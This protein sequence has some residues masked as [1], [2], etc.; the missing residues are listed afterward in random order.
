M[1]TKKAQKA[2]FKYCCKECDF[3][4]DKKQS[5]TRHLSTRKHKMLTD[6]DKK[7]SLNFRTAFFK[8]NIS[9]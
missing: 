4:A 5:Y 7:S 1:L 8:K 6:V 3:Y 9:S 2:H